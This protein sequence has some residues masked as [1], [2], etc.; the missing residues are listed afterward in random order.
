[1]HD[2]MRGGR[3]VGMRRMDAVQGMVSFA[4]WPPF[5]FAGSVISHSAKDYDAIAALS[6]L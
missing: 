1:M 3:S 2:E 5:R 6:V 4:M